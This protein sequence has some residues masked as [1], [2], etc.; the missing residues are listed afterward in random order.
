MRTTVNPVAARIAFPAAVGG[1]ALLGGSLALPFLL[2]GLG[3]DWRWLAPVSF[4]AGWCL[5]EGWVTARHRPGGV[6][7]GSRNLG[8]PVV[9]G[10]VAL[11]VAI[12]ALGE[13]LLC[14]RGQAGGTVAP[15]AVMPGLGWGIG[16]TGIALRQVAIR[17]LG[18]RFR[19]D[20]A[21]GASHEIETGGIYR[22]MAHPGE[23]GFGMAMVGL[24][25]LTGSRAGGVLFLAVLLPLM[26]IRVRRENRLMRGVAPGEVAATPG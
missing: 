3:V 16:L 26:V 8:L 5:V 23:L 22:W 15:V 7:G 13:C 6:P 4:Q 2:A 11:G 20:V 21:L 12:A 9:T 18:D 25:L 10:V 14:L 1:A 24:V 19:D 17:T